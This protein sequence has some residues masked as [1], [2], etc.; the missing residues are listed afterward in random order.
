M[1]SG[2]EILPEQVPE[3]PRVLTDMLNF[4]NDANTGFDFTGIQQLWEERGFFPDTLS[5]FISF[6]QTTAD[7]IRD[8]GTEAAINLTELYD[9]WDYSF[10]VENPDLAQRMIEAFNST[11]LLN[12]PERLVAVH[13]LSKNTLKILGGIPPLN[14]EVQ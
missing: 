13:N 1:S 14:L 11:F 6:A 7:Y 5:V 10:L 12:R 9:D 2:F 8:S 4:L 3:D